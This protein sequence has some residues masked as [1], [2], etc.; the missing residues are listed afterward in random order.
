MSS[1]GE[2]NGSALIDE[3]VLPVEADLPQ[4]VVFEKGL[5]LKA[6]TGKFADSEDSFVFCY[7]CIDPSQQN[8]SLR[9]TIRLVVDA[10]L[11]DQQSG[12]GI[13]VADTA[14]SPQKWSR[15]RNHLLLG[16]FGRGHGLGV[17]LVAGHQSRDAS[18]FDGERTVDESRM[19]DEIWD[20]SCDNLY[21]LSLIKTDKGFIASCNGREIVV[22][23]C[24]FLQAQDVSSISVG[25]AA[26]RGVSIEVSDIAF[27]TS[28][29]K[30][31]H[32]PEGAIQNHVPDYPFSRTILKQSGQAGETRAMQD[33]I[34]NETLYVS[35]NGKDGADGSREH[36]VS[37]GAALE[38]VAPGS[39]IMLLDGL[40]K[41]TAPLIIGRQRNGS[42]D[43]P[44]VL[45]AEHPRMAV[46]DGS[47]L[48]EG[49]PLCVLDA[50]FWQIN[51]LG[52][53]SSPHSGITICGSFNRVVD[54]E[55]HHNG[56]T[57]I[58]IISRPGAQRCDWPQH[59]MIKDCDS[60]SNCDISHSNADGFG[61]KLR[62]GAGNVFYRC[63]AHHNIDDGF[64]L[65][66]KSTF[67][68]IEPV[69]LDSCI[70]YSNGFLSNNQPDRATQ[71]GVGFKLGGE[72]QPVSHEVWNCLAVGNAKNGFASNSNP[73][74]S[75]HF[76]TAAF[77][78]QKDSDDI[79]LGS[80]RDPQWVQERVRHLSR[81]QY[82]PCANDIAS[83]NAEGY[84]TVNTTLTQHP[85]GDIRRG[86]SFGTRRN[87][88]IMVGSIGGGG[89]ER[90]ACR[91][92]GALSSHHNVF[93]MY[94]TEKGSET[95]P[96]DPGVTL[97]K[98]ASPDVPVFPTLLGRRLTSLLTLWRRRS[99]LK[100]FKKKEG[101][102]TTISLLSM[103]NLLNAICKGGRRIVCERND[104]SQKPKRYQQKIAVS[105]KRAEYVV[106]Q[107]EK[108]RRM[109]PEAVQ[110]K[111]CVIPNPVEI[112][113]IAKPNAKKKIVTVGRLHPQKNYPLL[114]KAYSI[115]EAT[116]PG[117]SLHMFGVGAQLDKLRELADALGVAD[118]VI[119]EGFC[120][121]VHEAI[122]DAQMFVLS[123]DYEGMPNALIEAMM[124]GL[125]CISTACT[126]SDE[127]IADGQNGLLVPVGDADSLAAAM[128][129]L[130]DNAS[131]RA[132]L[133]SNARIKALD[134]ALDDVIRKWERIL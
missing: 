40:Y 7:T 70:A 27:R 52:F 97:V 15:H 102:E 4:S 22:P 64:D 65:Y 16:G 37:V 75:L 43:H 103:P 85:S 72:N 5:T 124:M 71:G 45:A 30:A 87:I 29:G 69:E 121:D 104:P 20:S 6:R 11:F 125:P 131:L 57:G 13:L 35:P 51:G 92:A 8:F 95:Y 18:E 129:R 111:S 54:C 14:E 100:A 47:L 94:F 112:T 120:P 106:F 36:P 127:L 21:H 67:G 55:A 133:A 28:T 12:F 110:Q 41:P 50:D 77:N 56:D 19:I 25:F 91:M 79:K 78:G 10:S 49:Q 46:L 76:C 117:Y 107:T 119:F 62:V 68:P 83:R 60:H 3:A 38:L 113:C 132:K 122:S 2:A 42:I 114:L 59:N 48:E 98:A 123:S 134:F 128:G 39:C 101:I 44:I 66:T 80:M 99:M 74:G 82:F 9:A 90:V 81:N 108:V 1:L 24:D 58:L 61:A 116:H 89:A 126:G 32:T 96:I 88:L 84:L 63:I 31:S 118:S 105:C 34:K 93:L 17:R 33:T 109:F 26:A 23:G 86:A 53:C 73:L 115:F 130:A